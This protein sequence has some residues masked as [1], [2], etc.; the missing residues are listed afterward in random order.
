MAWEPLAI[1]P[2]MRANRVLIGL[3]WSFKK[4]NY[5]LFYFRTMKTNNST[6]QCREI[7]SNQYSIKLAIQS[8]KKI[9]LAFF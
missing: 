2:R 8:L 3:G 7:L 1:H 9:M 5:E 4:D 6:R